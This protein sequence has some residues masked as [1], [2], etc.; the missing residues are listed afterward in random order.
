MVNAIAPI[1]ATPEVAVVQP[2]YYPVLLHARAAL[3]VAVDV[4]VEGATVQ[5]EFPPD[6]SRWPYRVADLGPFTLVDA[7]ASVNANN[8]VNANNVNANNRRLAVTLVNRALSAEPARIVLR[9]FVF[10]G[11]A[12]ITTVT[13]GGAPEPR[14][15]RDVAT[16]HLEEGSEQPIDGTVELTLPPQSFTVVEAS[17]AAS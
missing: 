5:P 10:D 13:A 17:I 16:A 4:H 14:T 1:V 8:Y 6:A 2:T 15:L 12:A 9:D 7:A 3:D 11:A